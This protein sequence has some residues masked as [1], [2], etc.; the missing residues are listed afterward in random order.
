[1]GE[2]LKEWW[3]CY[4]KGYR[5]V[6]IGLGEG[7]REWWYRY[8]KGYMGKGWGL[9]GELKEWWYSVVLHKGLQLTRE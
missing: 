6:G 2:G 5:G 1:V 9:S 8:M 3:K 4:M 7:L